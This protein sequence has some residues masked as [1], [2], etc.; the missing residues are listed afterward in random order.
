MKRTAS[1]RLAVLILPLVWANVTVAAG[2]V[3]TSPALIDLSGPWMSN[4]GPV[5][6]KQDG[7]SIAGSFT[8]GTQRVRNA[9]IQGKTIPADQW[10][11]ERGTITDGVIDSTKK[12]LV[13][14]FHEAQ[15]QLDGVVT[16]TL[17]SDGGTLEGPYTASGM[18]GNRNGTW[19][20]W[21]NKC[22][23]AKYLVAC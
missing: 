23:S 12:T 17:S 8:E 11:A 5:I 2:D 6:F 19:T 9:Y 10:N 18:G 4:F 7:S 14:K 22:G 16:L 3:Q 1:M 13:F 21:R 15:D 20:M